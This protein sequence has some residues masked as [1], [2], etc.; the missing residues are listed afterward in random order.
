[1]KKA[2]LFLL[3]FSLKTTLLFITVLLFP[4][5]TA[6]DI[7][8]NNPYQSINWEN[9][10]QHKA[11]FHTHT[12][13]SDGSLN[14][15][16]VVDEY[17]DM[18]YSILAITDHNEVTYPWTA[19]SSMKPSNTSLGRLK[20]NPDRYEQPL[21]F[22]DR[23]PSDLH[24]IAIQANEVSAPHHTGSFFNGFNDRQETEEESWQGIADQGGIGIVFHPG[25]YQ[26]RNPEKYS[27]Q[28]YVNQF[29]NFPHLIGL[30]VYNQGDRYPND[31]ILYDSILTELMPQ[32][33]LWAFSND[34]MHGRK[35][36]GRNWNVFPLSE[37]S[38]GSVRNAM[39]E[40]CFYYIYAPLGHAGPE[41]LSIQSIKVDQ[42]KGSVTIVASNAKEF[43]WI[44]G[45]DTLQRGMNN[46]IH[47][48]DYNEIKGY[49]R[50]EIWGE[51]KS[52]LGTQP[53]GLEE[54]H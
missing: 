8:I 32:R 51:G 29:L 4:F 17:H 18:G 30:E 40:G 46:S 47:V 3:I 43:L 27:S 42:K 39:Q 53:F 44:S 5:C 33:N 38:S 35:A 48:N 28:W 2:T 19:F 1:M 21:V 25:R 50:A 12:V 54:L 24:M 16:V 26:T 6:T 37:H 34:D 31:R 15:Q 11:N 23:N 9:A 13:R 7:K 52:V 10:E 36:L 41:P 22:E 14:P 45:E 49:I 20:E